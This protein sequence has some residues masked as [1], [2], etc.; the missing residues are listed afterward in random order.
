MAADILIVDD[1]PTNLKILSSML[2]K[3][4]HNVRPVPNGKLALQ[5][6]ERQPPDLILLD[7]NMPEMDGY[8]VCENLK[9]ND[10][11]RDIPVIFISALSE[12]LD[13]IKAF[14]VGG[15]D[16]VTKPFQF[17][18]VEA[19]VETHL[20]LHRL[21]VE[22][23]KHNLLLAELVELKVKEIADSRMATIF[24]LAKLAESR[25]DSTGKHL[26]RVRSFCRLLALKLQEYPKYKKI[27]DKDFVDSLYLASPLHDIGKVG[28]SDS[29]LLKPAKLTTVEFEVMKEHTSIGAATLEAVQ[30]HYPS[31]KFITIG[32][33]IAR[34]HHERWDGCGYPQSLSGENI[35]LCAR[36]MAIADVYDALRS[37]RHYKMPLSHEDSRNMILAGK[38]THFDPELI[39]VFM[40]IEIEFN[41]EFDSL[42]D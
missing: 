32:I 28:I 30:S 40:R 13:K 41:V 33:D 31:N 19:R 5:A 17:E 26:E 42:I 4:G 2:K 23:E 24:A 8:E 34:S 36:I 38:E 18:E 9:A 25:D 20:K 39:D 35:P 27:V 22:L 29:I 21:Q 14:S 15:V 3:Q 7:I 6:A 1:V 12:T 10:A 16:Y 37:W 11:L